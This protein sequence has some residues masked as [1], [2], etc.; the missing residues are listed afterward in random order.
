MITT[1]ISQ[2]LNLRPISLIDA[3]MLQR[4]LT[5]PDDCMLLGCDTFESQAITNRIVRHSINNKTGTGCHWV[6]E[7]RDLRL[8]IGFCDVQLPA[9]HMKSLQFCDIAFGLDKIHRGQGYMREA[10]S[11]CITHLFNEVRMRRI[12][13]NV[14]PT[15]QASAKLL[16][17][18]GFRQE[19]FQRQKWYWGGAAQDVL[20]Y[21]LLAPEF[22]PGASQK[23]V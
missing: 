13:A 18:L 10:L 9:E 16:E 5:A 1:L 15:N 21:A 17:K 8:P 22:I 12:E 20:A 11:A 19:G 7:R 14:T 4:L 6:I 3:G 23:L 2:R